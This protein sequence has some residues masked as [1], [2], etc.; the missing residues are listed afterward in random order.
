VNGPNYSASSVPSLW[1]LLRSATRDVKDPKTGKTV[2]QQWQDH[3]REQRNETDSDYD[4]GAQISPLGSGSD[5]TPFLQH[6]GIASTDMGFG[7]DYGVYHSAF[8][9]FTWM[10]KFGDPDFAYHVAAAQLWGTM[11]M[12]LAGAEG[13]QFDY[14][15]YAEAI[16]DYFNEAMRLAKRRKLDSAIDE[17][18]MNDAIKNFAGEANRI[19]RERQRLIVESDKSLSDSLKLD[20]LNDALMQTERAFVDERGLNGR[21]WY[22]HEIYAPGIFTGYASQPLT[23]FRQALDDRNT[24]NLK[25]GLERIIAA[26]NRATE[27]LKKGRD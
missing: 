13:L 11:A 21:P 18:A 4:T 1:K 16:S 17:K 10:S 15:D 3:A 8:D 19:E 9:S 14:R 24:T 12:R 22:R 20:R 2:Y 6:L 7:G 26:I 5:Y 27:V 25:S 23:D